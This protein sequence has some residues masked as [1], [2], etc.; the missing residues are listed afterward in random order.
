[1]AVFAAKID[2]FEKNY[3]VVTITVIYLQK[4]RK[5]LSSTYTI[6]DRKMNILKY[7]ITCFSLRVWWHF[8]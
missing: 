4:N 6:K 2:S 5:N 3:I 8:S 1:M 7:T